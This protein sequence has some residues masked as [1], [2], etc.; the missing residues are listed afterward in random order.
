MPERLME[1]HRRQNK[2]ESQRVKREDLNFTKKTLTALDR[3]GKGKFKEIE[4]K[5]FL[6][7]LE[8]L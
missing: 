7:E 1:Y 8:N 3:Y 5:D 4:G 6:K 2:G